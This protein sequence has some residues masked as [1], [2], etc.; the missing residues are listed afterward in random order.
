M[1]P[2]LTLMGGVAAAVIGAVVA[3]AIEMWRRTRKTLGFEVLSRGLIIPFE[4]QPGDDLEIRVKAE[5]VG[6]T[7]AAEPFVPAGRVYGFRVRLKNSGNVPIESQEIFITL[8]PEAK[9]LSLEVEE[10]P[11]ELQDRIHC[12]RQHGD[13][14]TGRCTVPFLNP[15][16]D[17]IVSLQSVDNSVPACA[18]YAPGAGLRVHDTAL[19]EL[20]TF[21]LLLL[22]SLGG[23]ALMTAG[24][25]FAFTESLH[26]PWAIAMAVAGGTMFLLSSFPLVILSRAA[27]RRARRSWTGPSSF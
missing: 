9:M 6:R 14:F 1:E 19:T 11:L 3:V 7:D 12:E 25:A 16:Q 5:L 21:G 13:P 20:V 26:R 4:S 2:I 10:A 24:T 27:G 23:Y 8:D 18:V 15:G 22:A 17:F